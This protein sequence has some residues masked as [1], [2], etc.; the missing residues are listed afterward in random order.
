MLLWS[1][2]EKDAYGSQMLFAVSVQNHFTASPVGPQTYLVVR[3]FLEY[4]IM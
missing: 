4:L 1:F 3:I 2:R